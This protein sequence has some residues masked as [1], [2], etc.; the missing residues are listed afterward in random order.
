MWYQATERS[1]EVCTTPQKQLKC[2][3]A[4][5]SNQMSKWN[6]NPIL[7]AL[8]CKMTYTCPQPR[9]ISHRIFSPPVIF[10][11]DDLLILR[12]LFF[13]PESGWIMFWGVASKPF[14][15]A[16]PSVKPEISPKVPM[17]SDGRSRNWRPRPPETC[18]GM[19]QCNNQAPGLSAWKAITA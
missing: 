12:S 4:E 13:K 5:K 18:H 14:Q 6:R 7:N 19:W 15:A 1:R 2:P 17:I 10:S 3:K 16:Q 9:A 8:Q 11:Y